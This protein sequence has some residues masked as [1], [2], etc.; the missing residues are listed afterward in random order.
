MSASPEFFKPAGAPAFSPA[1]AA[2]PPL[3]FGDDYDYD[4]RTPTG[5]RI[6]Y[7]REPTTCPPAPR[8]PPCRKRLFQGDQPAADPSSVPLISLRLDELE[9]LFRPHPHPPP[10]ATTDKRRRSASA[11]KHC[12]A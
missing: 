9:R 11:N 4:C 3:V 12:A 10:P 1:C 5:S 7:L 2:L 6:S 8:K